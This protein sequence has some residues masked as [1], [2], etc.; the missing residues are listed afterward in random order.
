MQGF[1][2][3]GLIVTR[4]FVQEP[5][6]AGDTFCQ[7]AKPIYWSSADTRATKEQVDAHNRKWKRLCKK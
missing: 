2:C 3:V 5:A 7:I 4:C 6:S 1:W